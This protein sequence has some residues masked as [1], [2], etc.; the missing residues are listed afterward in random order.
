MTTFNDIKIAEKFSTKAGQYVKTGPTSFYGFLMGEFV[1]S[2]RD[3]DGDIIP[4]GSASYLEEM[5][6]NHCSELQEILV[7]MA[8]R[9]EEQQPKTD[10]A[11]IAIGSKARGL[12]TGY[13]E[14]GEVVAITT[15]MAYCVMKGI[16]NKYEAEE[17][18]QKWTNLYPD[19][20][21]NLIVTLMYDNPVCP[22]SLQDYLNA[23][24]TEEDYKDAPFT[25]FVNFPEEDI[26][27]AE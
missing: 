15:A 26:L 16:T 22:Y 5:A 17:K 20:T 27:K 8:D 14:A 2:E 13:A 4:C 11:L 9:L 12:K 6:L 18:F 25:N 24:L 23:G 7:E 21:D 19:W 3:M 1:E 10:D